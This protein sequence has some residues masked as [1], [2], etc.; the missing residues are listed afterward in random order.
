MQDMVD[1]NRQASGEKNGIVKLTQKD[2]LDIRELY[3][4]GGVTQ[5]EL[6]LTYGVTQQ[7]IYY[8]VSGSTWK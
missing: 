5:E 2:V 4:K 8:V 7:N 1:T 6:G 3:A